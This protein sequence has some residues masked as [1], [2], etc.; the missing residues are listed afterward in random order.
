MKKSDLAPYHFEHFYSTYLNAIDDLELHNSLLEGMHEFVHFIGSIA[1]D[2]FQNTYMEGK[3]T[4]AE[5]LGH[6]IDTERVFQYR[7]LR[8]SRNDSTPLPGFD[9]DLFVF[10]ADYK[11]RTAESFVEE[12]SAVRKSTITLFQNFTEAQL[13][14]RGIASQIPWSVAGLGFVISGHQAHH[15]RILEE[16]YLGA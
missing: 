1:K 12:Y 8:F 3:W 14:R 9:Q 2:C 10:S 6:I 13:H 16:R 15:K 7:A 11:L 5:V 4:L